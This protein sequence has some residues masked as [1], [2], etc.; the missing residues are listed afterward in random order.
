[1]KR[2][3]FSNICGKA[4]PVGRTLASASS[5][6][7]L[8]ARSSESRVGVLGTVNGLPITTASSSP[9]FDQSSLGSDDSGICCS[10]GDREKLRLARS[11]EYLE[12]DDAMMQFDESK[13]LESDEM[14]F[15]SETLVLPVSNTVPVPPPTHEETASE[16]SLK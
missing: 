1:M 4:E 6:P 10:S 8:P 2:E 12:D 7:V 9:N 15:S 14:E 5:S 16:T 11:V 3:R 13:S